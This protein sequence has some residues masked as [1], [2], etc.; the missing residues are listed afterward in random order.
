[1]A[2]DPDPDRRVCPEHGGDVVEDALRDARAHVALAATHAQLGQGDAAAKSLT[3][4]L[5]LRPDF[6]L[7][8]RVEVEKY[9]APEMVE[10]IID[11]LR[12]AATVE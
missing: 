5:G 11:G 6:A 1:M 3:D 9:H 10:R 2:L 12:K 7:V 8:G 4:L